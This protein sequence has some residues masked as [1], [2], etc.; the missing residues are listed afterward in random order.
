M[1]WVNLLRPE[2]WLLNNPNVHKP[3]EQH[4]EIHIYIPMK[5][6]WLFDISPNAGVH[7]VIG[8]HL[9]RAEVSSDSSPPPAAAVDL[10]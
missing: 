6:V 5:R 9:A 4:V 1:W 7:A 8:Q 10:S 3:I 2:S